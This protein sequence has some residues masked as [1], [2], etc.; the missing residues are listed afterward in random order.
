MVLYAQLIL[1]I[2]LLII[3]YLNLVRD[4]EFGS[5]INHS[6]KTT[7]FPPILLKPCSA[8]VELIENEFW[9]LD[10]S[11]LLIESVGFR[12]KS[13]LGKHAISDFNA[14]QYTVC[15]TS[16]ASTIHLYT[17]INICHYYGAIQSNTITRW[18]SYLTWLFYMASIIIQLQ[19]MKLC[20]VQLL[21]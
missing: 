4:R 7:T 12:E 19:E 15:T 8:L 1:C 20:T 17:N 9:S 13:L 5:V 18:T 11:L 6:K 14:S 3:P 10:H 2:Y 16:I 21:Y